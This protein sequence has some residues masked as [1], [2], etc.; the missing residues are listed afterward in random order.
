MLKRWQRITKLRLCRPT[1]SIIWFVHVSVFLLFYP[2][3]F[4]FILLVLTVMGGK[5]VYCYFW[6]GV[7]TRSSGLPLQP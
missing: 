6:S 2:P 4:Y 3:V 1:G 5:C 7:A